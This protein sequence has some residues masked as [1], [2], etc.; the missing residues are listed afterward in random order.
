MKAALVKLFVDELPKN[1]ENITKNDKYW[2][3]QNALESKEAEIQ[4]EFL[5]SIKPIFD[6]FLTKFQKEE[7]MIHLLYPNCEKLLR[8]TIGRLMKN[9]VYKDKRGEDLKKVNVEKVEMQLTSDQFK[10]MQG[11]KV[12]TLMD[13]DDNLSK[14]ALLGMISFYKAVIKYLQDNL[15]LDNEL[16]K[17]LTCLNPREQ[18]SSKSK[19]YC[20]TV[21][22]AMPCITGDEKVKVEMNG[23]DIKK[24]KLTMMTFK[25]ALI[26]S[27]TGSS[28]FLTNVETF[29]KFFLKW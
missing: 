3:I 27:G 2:T 28:I 20:K 25:G 4:M 7:P 11:H 26:I 17:A 13:T 21:A 22:S 12:V 29:L 10:Q 9:K 6:E 23:S 8:L 5:I 18:N 1:D 24:L 15:P 14:R 19:E 16:L